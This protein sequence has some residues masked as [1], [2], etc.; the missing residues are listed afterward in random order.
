MNSEPRHVHI[1]TALQSAMQ[2]TL[3]DLCAR[4]T[5]EK[6]ETPSVDVKSSDVGQDID[7]VISE[8]PVMCFGACC[9]FGQINPNQPR[10]RD[11]LDVTIKIIHTQIRLV[12]ASWFD[13][14]TWL[15]LC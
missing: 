2:K 11:V 3:F 13:R 10:T 9:K 15:T 5:E 6:D 14:Y 12:S 7:S 4:N 1:R 8:A